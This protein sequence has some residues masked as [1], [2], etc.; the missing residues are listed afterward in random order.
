MIISKQKK[1]IFLAVPK[2]GTTFAEDYFVR[3]ISDAEQ[4]SANQHGKQPQLHKHSGIIDM[5]YLMEINEYESYFKVAFTRNPY[6]RVVSWFSYLTQRRN[7]ENTQKIHENF[8]GSKYMS[9]SFK[10]F[11][12][13]APDWCFSNAASFIIN[14]HGQ[15]GCD[16]VGRHEN[17][18]DDINIIC[19]KIKIPYILDDTEKVNQSKH[20]HYT[21]YYCDQTRKLVSEKMKLDIDYFKYKFGE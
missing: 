11:V 18:V 5:F 8:Y 17:Y 16:F 12:I 9:G 6:E 10:D 14:K 13:N 3:H 2:T 19:E 1:F 20:R 7:D 4:I 21:T 15:L